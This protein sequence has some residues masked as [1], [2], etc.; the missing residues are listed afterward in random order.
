MEIVKEETPAKSW[1][2]VMTEEIHKA[3]KVAKLIRSKVLLPDFTI[4]DMVKL[5]R[6]RQEDASGMIGQIAQ[7]GYLESKKVNGTMHYKIIS[8]AQQRIDQINGAIEIT[9]AQAQAQVDR[10][11]VMANVTELYKEA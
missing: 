2:E 9:K 11:T 4:E 1:V 7:F 6:I 3:D 10:F 8:D 5:M